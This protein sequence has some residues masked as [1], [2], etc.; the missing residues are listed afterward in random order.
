[1]QYS[2]DR[3]QPHNH[4]YGLPPLRH[5]NLV[6]HKAQERLREK[7]LSEKVVSVQFPWSKVLKSVFVVCLILAAFILTI[8]NLDVLKTRFA[9]RQQAEKTND[10]TP[11][12][13]STNQEVARKE[14][15]AFALEVTPK[16]ASTSVIVEDSS[17]QKSTNT[18]YLVVVSSL[19]TQQSAEGELRRIKTKYKKAFVLERGDHYR[20]VADSVKSERSIAQVAELLRHK[21]ARFWLM[22]K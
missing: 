12:P 10:N 20:I 16:I 3:E 9:Q 22:R 17:V 2:S 15:K 18:T 14:V 8:R 19:K 6:Q 13:I 11:T 4:G 21:Y 1:M 5:D 7:K